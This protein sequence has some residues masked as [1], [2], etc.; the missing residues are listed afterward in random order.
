MRKSSREAL[1]DSGEMLL[2]TSLGT[3]I[4]T[5]ETRSTSVPIGKVNQIFS[6]RML[7]NVTS[8]SNELAAAAVW[9]IWTAG[10]SVFKSLTRFTRC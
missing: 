3:A 8:K 9:I 2:F 1:K 5:I 6:P 7:C 4:W 10:S